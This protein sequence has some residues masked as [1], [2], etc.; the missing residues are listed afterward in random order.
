[1]AFPALTE[2]IIPLLSTLTT[3]VLLDVHLNSVLSARAPFNST[4]KASVL[5]SPIKGLSPPIILIL[6]SKASTITY[7][8]AVTVYSTFPKII[9][10]VTVIVAM[11]DDTA[12]TKPFLS[13]IAI[14]LLLEDHA[15]DSILDSTGLR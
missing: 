15:I 13:T 3:S 8:S 1:M 6:S 9:S 7:D 10:A 11:P 5:P 12:V 14:S 2:V 4:S